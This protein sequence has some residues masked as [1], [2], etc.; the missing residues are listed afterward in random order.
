MLLVEILST[1]CSRTLL[2]QVRKKVDTGRKRAGKWERFP[3][4]VKQQ[5]QPETKYML[6]AIRK[7]F[8]L[9]GLQIYASLSYI[10]N[11]HVVLPSY[12]LKKNQLCCHVNFIITES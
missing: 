1:V 12:R 10:L 8:L 7:K 4:R 11:H 3:N 2:E 6:G 5:E 9:G